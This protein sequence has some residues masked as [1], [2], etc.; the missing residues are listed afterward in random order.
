MYKNM[1]NIITSNYIKL[2]R[3]YVQLN[4]SMIKSDIVYSYET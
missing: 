4:V 1:C 3:L 2:N